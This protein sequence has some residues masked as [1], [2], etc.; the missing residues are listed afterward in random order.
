MPVEATSAARY[1]LAAREDQEPRQAT[2]PARKNGNTM[3]VKITVDGKSIEAEAG[4]QLIDVLIE[5]GWDIPHFCY[6][7]GLGPDG[8][9]RMCQIEIV[10]PR[11]PM[12]AISCNTKV[13][14]GMEV[15]TDS[16][17]VKRVRAAVEEF[18]LLNH[19]LDCPICD[20]AGECSLQNYYMQHDL[21]A[22]RQ[23]FERFKKRKA[24]D[25]GP[26]LILDRERCVLCDRCVRF[27]RDWAG[28]EQLYIAGRGHGAYLTTFPGKKVTSPY[29][30]NTVDLCPVGA[31]TSKD[32]RF[33]TP[34]WFL[35]RTASVCTTCSRGCSIEV[36]VDTRDNTVRRLR[37]RFNPHVNGY[38]MC[39]EGRVNYKFVNTDRVEKPFVDRRGEK[40][41][42]SMEN[43]LAEAT[44]I[45]GGKA[46]GSIAAG[47]KSPPD[48]TPLV[49]LVSA[50]CTLEEMYACKMLA[51]S[52]AH[53]HL[54]VAHHV[55]DGVEDRLLRKSDRHPNRKGAELLGLHVVDFGA[56]PSTGGTPA[57]APDVPAGAA[58]FAVG[59]DYGIGEPLEKFFEK[60][61]RIAMIAARESALTQRAHVVMPGLT[62]AE[63]EGLVVNFEGH[64]QKLAPALEGLWGQTP[65]W[66]IVARVIGGL[67]GER[68]WATIAGLR[69]YLGEK[70]AAFAGVDLNAVESVGVRLGEITV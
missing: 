70:E 27:L 44:A 52:R 7:P 33:A 8:N 50:T 42:A 29:S 64:V 63:K 11:G 19:P 53:A 37:P 20:K 49:V 58:L 32:F 56:E 69:Q 16:E 46:A 25:V 6:H 43:A 30:L 62:F 38:W 23:E 1:Q 68:R 39:D 28:E 17:R 10:T 59:F 57:G 41:P 4:R 36:D 55:P 60:F 40:I 9:C 21:R 15:V 47:A 45:V 34:T 5:N 14:D 22:G 65:P 13:T 48:V 66:E 24:L 31:L 54:Y 26:T 35:S 12:L 61:S 2:L 18:L 51:S 67:A 3:T